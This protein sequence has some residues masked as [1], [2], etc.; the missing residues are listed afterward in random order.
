VQ[1]L[2]RQKNFEESFSFCFMNKEEKHCDDT[3]FFTLEELYSSNGFGAPFSLPSD[4]VAPEK[5][6]REKAEER[7]LSIEEGFDHS[8]L[9]VMTC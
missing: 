4:V 1:E 9:S 2:Y 5:V 6:R 7:L 3:P 8:V